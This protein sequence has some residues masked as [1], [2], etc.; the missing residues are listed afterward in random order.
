MGRDGRTQWGSRIKKCVQGCFNCFPSHVCVS[1]FS[2]KAH[3]GTVLKC[4]SAHGQSRGDTSTLAMGCHWLNE[5]RVVSSQP[6]SARPSL[7]FSAQGVDRSRGLLPGTPAPLAT[8]PPPGKDM[9]TGRRRVLTSYRG[10]MVFWATSH[11]QP[12]LDSPCCPCVCHL[13]APRLVGG[14]GTLW[15]PQVGEGAVGRLGLA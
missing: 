9:C 15:A 10:S 4:L 6:C 13:A 12:L 8:M 7:S 3:G 14:R 1:G 11:L 2:S 5:G